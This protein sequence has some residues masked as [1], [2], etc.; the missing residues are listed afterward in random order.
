MFSPLP[1][2]RS[3]LMRS[4]VVGRELLAQFGR[5]LYGDNDPTKVFYEERPQRVIKDG[6]AYVLILKLPFVK[7]AE[8][9]ILKNEDGLT[10]QIGSYRRE[11]LLPSALSLLEVDNATLKEK[12]LRITFVKGE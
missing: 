2:L 4:E 7:K 10:I 6:D 5:D 1:I 9:D 3:K 8:L 11:I 12:E